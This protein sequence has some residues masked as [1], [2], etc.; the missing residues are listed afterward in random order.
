MSI[1]QL[2][3][4]SGYDYLTR[5][6]AAFDAT[7]KGHL[8]LTSYYTE[9]G[10]TPGLWIGF[11][12]AGIDG[13][14]AGDAVTAEQMRALFGAGRHPLATQQLE[15]LGAADLTSENIAEATRLGAPFKL[16]AGEVRPYRVEVAHRIATWH[17]AGQQRDQPVSAA[18][19]AQVRTE[20]AREFFRKQHGRDPVDAREIA[21]I[22]AKESRPHT[23]TV[24][25][26]DLTF[27]PVKS[28]SSLW[29]VADPH[30]AAQIE[31]AHQAA[32]Q[33]ALS[34]IE[35]HALFTRQGRNGVRQVNVTGLVAAAF[36]HRD[37]EPGIPTCTPTSLL[38]TR[39]RPWTD[40]GCPS[41]EGC[42]S[43]P[44]WR[45]RRPTTPPWSSISVT[46]WGSVRGSTGPGSGEAAGAGDR[47]RAS[48]A[49]S[50]LV[51][52]AGVDQGSA[53]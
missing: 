21:A 15:Q 46:G 14:S 53:R 34:F 7:E 47:R 28:V 3:A 52:A 48:G 37:S 43:R 30:L 45:S 41:T 11:G 8:G 27:S 42:C 38:R 10:E 49:E 2:S 1:H 32:V 20:V 26:Y 35:R 4:G 33:D 18:I 23:Q 29:A 50:T 5:Q 31:L 25:G 44:R 39:C 22:I 51:D 12:M 9:H 40:A 16:Y 17:A 6:V 19:R 24:A 36:T 13:L